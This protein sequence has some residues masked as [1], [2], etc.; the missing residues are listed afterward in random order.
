[1][2][3]IV[4]AGVSAVRAAEWV[5]AH[6]LYGDL[7][8]RP[9]LWSQ[10]REGAVTRFLA[11]E[12]HYDRPSMRPSYLRLVA[13]LSATAEGRPG[14]L[15]FPGGDILRK[16]PDCE[17]GVAARKMREA[18]GVILAGLAD[19]ID[20]EQREYVTPRWPKRAEELTTAYTWW[21]RPTT[22]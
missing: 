10:E 19:A 16:G 22:A 4:N 8:A 9:F 5:M 17:E 18:A 3:L 2:N 12:E 21:W 1:M 15:P 11:G 13:L 6:R 14:G 20:A 7:I